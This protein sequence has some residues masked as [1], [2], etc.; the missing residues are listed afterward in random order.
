[1][2]YSKILI[3]VDADHDGVGSIFPLLLTMF[4][5]LSPQLIT[6]GRIYLVNTP[7]YE[8]ELKGDKFKYAITDE[9][10]TRITEQLD[11]KG[12]KY[13]VGYI[14]GLGELNPETMKMTLEEDYENVI[15]VTLDDV[16]K[17]VEIL[18]IFMGDDIEIRKD[19]IL[20]EY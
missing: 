11:S 14:K 16:D 12:E 19:Y 8:I 15:Q 1:M 5:K 13:K 20:K 2:K 18:N 17:S 6:D 7:K 4:Y 10:L 3:Y 9:E